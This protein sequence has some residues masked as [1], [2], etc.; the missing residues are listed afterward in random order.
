MTEIAD[1]PVDAVVSGAGGPAWLDA[2]L[3]A[4]LPGL[5]DL[6]RDLHAH[7]E[8]AWQER[9]TT[10]LLAD[11]LAGA[12]L[13]ARHLGTGTGLIVDIGDGAERG[14]GDWHCAGHNAGPFVA[15]RADIDALPLPEESGLGFAST[16]PGVAHACGHDMHTTVVLGALL[17]LAQMPEPHG[18]VR[19]VFQPAEEVMPG[20]AYQVLAD[21]GLVGVERVFALHCDPGLRVGAVGLRAGA[22]TSACDMIDIEILGPGGHTSRP[23]LTVDI[24]EALAVVAAQLPALVARRTDPRSGTVLAWGVIRAGEA[25]NAVPGRGVLRGTLR[26][27]DMATW[28]GAE[29]LVTDLVGPL[30]APFGGE[31]RLRYTRGVPPVVNEDRATDLLRTGTVSALGAAAVTAAEQSTGGEDF[32]VLLTQ[33]PGALARLGV[34]D[35][36]SPQVDLHSPTFVADERAIEVG[37][38]TLVHTVLAAWGG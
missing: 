13:A 10:A 27:M 7:P 12:G 22:I 37:I 30:L 18:R 32:A 33:T 16:V 15:L 35:G 3:A 26:T 29:K 20:G 34:W 6:R 38:R 8:L 11:R 31:F 24:V 1:R 5:I 23:H 28:E 36:I 2:F 14:Y 17:A 9:R 25:P 4:E 21:G 19:G